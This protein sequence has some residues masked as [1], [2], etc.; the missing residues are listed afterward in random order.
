MSFR[1]CHRVVQSFIT[2]VSEAAGSYGKFAKIYQDTLALHYRRQQSFRNRRKNL[3]FKFIK[4]VLKRMSI[5]FHS[6]TLFLLSIRELQPLTRPL[7]KSLRLQFDTHLLGAGLNYKQDG[8]SLELL[9]LYSI[10][11]G[12]KGTPFSFRDVDRYV[13]I[14]KIPFSTYFVYSYAGWNFRHSDT[15]LFFCKDAYTRY[16]VTSF[17]EWMD[18]KKHNYTVHNIVFQ[19]PVALRSDLVYYVYIPSTW[20]QFTPQ[21]SCCLCIRFYKNNYNVQCYN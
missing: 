9:L 4:Y 8:H 6:K 3:D 7:F 11:C 21:H 10:H 15:G 18:F 19:H 5:W 14:W 12:N 2:D 17:V 1:M 16:D 13:I 20:S